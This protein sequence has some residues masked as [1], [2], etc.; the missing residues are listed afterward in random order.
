[1]LRPLLLL[2]AAIATTV[3]EWMGDDQRRWPRLTK[4][5]SA[6]IVALVA[7]SSVF[8]GWLARREGIRAY[9]DERYP[10]AVDRLSLAANSFFASDVVLGYLATSYKILADFTDESSAR[11]QYYQRASEV[12][13]DGIARYKSSPHCW[14][15]LINVYRNQRKWADLDQ[16]KDT[17]E[18]KLRS[19]S[20]RVQGKPLSADLRAKYYVT[21]G[22][23]FADEHYP[24]YAIE[25]SISYYEEALSHDKNNRFVRLNLPARY[26]EAARRSDDVRRR[27]DFYQRAYDLAVESTRSANQQDKAFTLATAIEALTESRGTI[28]SGDLRLD[29]ALRQFEKLAASG[30]QIYASDWLVVAEAYLIRG[31]KILACRAAGKAFEGR[32]RLSASNLARVREVH[33]KLNCA[34]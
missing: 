12:A 20:F 34:I 30:D 27:R 15:V 18:Q 26:N 23:V 14:N 2:A 32:V 29:D 28:A 16:I 25:K 5:V 17:F 10:T 24:G 3:A 11:D 6:L 31:E 19:G 1:M 33:N 9:Q 22:N 13:R 8:D 7:F 4:F 21:L